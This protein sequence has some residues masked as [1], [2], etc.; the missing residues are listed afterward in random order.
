[1]VTGNFRIAFDSITSAKWRSFL[2][3]LG[4][5]IGV[6][7]V[8][9]IVSIGEGV[10]KQI[11]DQIGE[12]GTDL[13][14]IRPG[15]P[16]EKNAAGDVS[17]IN[18]LTA[19]A[20][21]ALTENDLKVAA[22]TP[23]V[24]VAVPMSFVT[25]TPV[26]DDVQYK[27][28]FIFATSEN[29]PKVLNHSVEYG[30]FFNT[31]DADKPVAVIGEKVAEELFQE[32]VPIG[33]SLKIRGETF[34]V[35][36]VFEKFDTSRLTL[37]ADY[38]H[39]IFIPFG[40]GKRLNNNQSNIQ[41]ILIKPSSHDQTTQTIDVLQKQLLNAHAGQDDFTILTQAD[42]LAVASTILNL[43]TRFIT[44]VAAIS[45]IVGGIGIMNIMLVSV[46]QRT[47]EIGIRKAVGATNRQI[48]SQFLIE[49][50]VISLV[51]GI[52][53]VIGSLIANFLIRVTTD[54]EP[55]ITLPIMFL[56]VAISILVGIVF[57]VAPA[58][59]A[60]RKDPIQALRR[61]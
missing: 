5:I 11:S 12:F 45:L 4:I 37:S 39:A 35:R 10:K 21:N 48:L 32:T 2:T 38:N 51:G 7:S 6:M 34:V 46:T 59:Q 42:N 14:T 17:G 58:L 25:G 40:V 3:T 23:G 44:G 8:V 26:A 60:A 47:Q 56:A 9:T 1:M 52:L 53:G 20:G 29:L 13:I 41:Q 31:E 33:R 43:L 50:V 22:S 28:G 18:F 49:A 19:F 24:G 54:L 27:A 55:L 57:G 15:K 36:G 61:M 30:A 16:V